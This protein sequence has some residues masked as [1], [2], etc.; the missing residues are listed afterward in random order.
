MA[1]IQ[2]VLRD[3]AGG[4]HEGG[5]HDSSDLGPNSMSMIPQAQFADRTPTTPLAL[6]VCVSDGTEEKR[7]W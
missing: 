2:T 3:K 7:S 4:L 5:W 1:P 6:A